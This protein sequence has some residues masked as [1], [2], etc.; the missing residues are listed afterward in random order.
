M[1]GL[2]FGLVQAIIATVALLLIALGL[3]YRRATEAASRFRI[4][5]GGIGSFRASPG[6]PTQ[7]D[8]SSF[9]RTGEDEL[10]RGKPSPEHVR[11]LGLVSWEADRAD[12]IESAYMRRE[13]RDGGPAGDRGFG[14]GGGCRSSRGT[15]E[16]CGR[17]TRAFGT[18]R[19]IGL[20]RVPSM[21]PRVLRAAAAARAFTPAVAGKRLAMK[22]DLAPTSR[23][24]GR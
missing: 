19:A 10:L 22:R 13:R 2:E 9:V 14:I 20:K 21:I 18:D 1:K 23:F 6:G 11:S 5:G 8:H 17:A 16:T 7:Q 3:T 12:R 4:P 24:P 15:E